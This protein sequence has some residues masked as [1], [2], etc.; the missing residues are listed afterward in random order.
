MRIYA[1]AEHQDA[2]RQMKKDV[3]SEAKELKQLLKEAE[4]SSPAEESK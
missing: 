4:T 2:V 3:E 1:E